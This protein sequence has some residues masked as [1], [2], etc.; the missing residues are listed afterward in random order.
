[1]DQISLTSEVGR[2]VYGSPG[3]AVQDIDFS[4]NKP[5]MMADG[6]T[7]R[8]IF[9]F[10]VA[11]PKQPG[12]QGH[13][14]NN[15]AWGSPI[16]Q[17]GHAAFP[18]A[19]ARPDFSWKIMDG[20][21]TMPNKKGTIPAHTE[22]NRGHWIVSFKNQFAPQLYNRDGS[23]VIAAQEFYTGAYVQ[24]R[25]DVNSNKSQANPGIYLNPV[26]VALSGHGEHIVNTPDVSVAGF[27]TAALPAG[28]SA[29]PV[30]GF[31]AT[32]VPAPASAALQPAAAYQQILQ[33]PV[34]PTH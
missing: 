2:L 23:Q 3:I 12:D 20:D 29:T 27:G 7:P 24:V 30:G 8:M 15:P 13:W 17:F 5:K 32:N 33:P 19:A 31:V 28:A 4:T 11:I 25:F 16:F 10:G 1:M 6:V 34:V 9:N 18:E 26:M 14:G 21:S 22:H